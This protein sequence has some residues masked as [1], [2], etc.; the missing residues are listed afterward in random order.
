M[1][2]DAVLVAAFVALT[3][4]CW[5]AYGP[6][7]HKGQVAMGGS[8]LRPLLC[9]G[10]AYFAI[11]VV[12]PSVLLWLGQESSGRFT[13]TGV[14]WS[15]FGGALGALGALGIILAF[16]YGGS[17]AYVM[18]FVFGFAPLVNGFIT[19]GLSGKYKEMNSLTLGGMMAGLIMVSMGAFIV[20]FCAQKVASHKPPAPAS[21]SVESSAEAGTH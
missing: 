15:L 17:P 18:P 20:L 3:F 21:S 14:S 19:V 6:T 7:L 13:F 16:N 5:G 9:V 11:A 8:R 2:K 12:V 10:L 1:I 4:V